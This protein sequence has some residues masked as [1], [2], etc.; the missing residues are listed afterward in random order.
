LKAG[1][2]AQEGIE[3]SIL[4]ALVQIEDVRSPF[5]RI[6]PGFL[7]PRRIR[8]RKES[9]ASWYPRSVAVCVVK[10]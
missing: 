4:L 3:Q 5:I 7:P 8:S 10:K 6:M 1:G 9:A 2:L